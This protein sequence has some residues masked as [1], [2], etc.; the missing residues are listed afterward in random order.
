MNGSLLAAVFLLSFPACSCNG[1]GGEFP[2]VLAH[3]RYFT[4]KLNI[5]FVYV[6]PCTFESGSPNSGVPFHKVSLSGYWISVT[7]ITQAQY[8]EL[9]PAWKEPFRG[10][11][12]FPASGLNLEEAEQ[13]ARKVQ[14]RCG[15]YYR[16]PTDTEWECAARG[17]IPRAIWPWGDDDSS[18]TVDA[19]GRFVSELPASVGSYPPNA[20]GLYDMVGEVPQF[21]LGQLY[22]TPEIYAGMPHPTSIRDPLY[23]CTTKDSPQGMMRGCGYDNLLKLEDSS[24]VDRNWPRFGGIRLVYTKKPTSFQKIYFEFKKAT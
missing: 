12:S 7:P 22:Q 9:V 8:K 5:K 11:P 6:Q 10:R 21:V 13:Y 24:P 1:L 19:G 15:E 16:L 2:H 14:N 20:F 17:G 23:I 18:Q 4:N 3:R